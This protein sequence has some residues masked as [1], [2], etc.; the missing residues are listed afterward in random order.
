[1]HAQNNHRK[2][3][4]MRS[5]FA[6]NTAALIGGGFLV[7]ASQ[8]FGSNATAWLALG[9]SLA[10][11]GMLGVAQLDR[12]RGMLQSVF[13]A[14]IGLLAIWS[15]VAAMVFNGSLLTWLLFGD[16]VGL[17]ALA[18]GA[19]VANEMSN[20]QTVRSLGTRSHGRTAMKAAEP[21]SAAA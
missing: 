21:T 9:V 13:D 10:T 20:E 17:V 14:A 16:A 1:M 8:A 2:E 18:L 6:T 3:H 15:A 4:V 5:R 19:L 7:V 12:S 11:L